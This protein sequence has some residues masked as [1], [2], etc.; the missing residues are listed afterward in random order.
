[1]SQHTA[2]NIESRG[3]NIRLLLLAFVAAGIA[4]ALVAWVL[5]TM[6]THKQEARQPFVRVVEIS[7]ISTDPEPWG[8]NWPH[9]FDGWKS[10]AGDKFYGGSSAMPESKLETQ[11]WLKR[12]YAGYAFSI[13]YR[14]ARGH[15]YMLYDQGVT[16]R[17]T[18]KPQAGA[19]LHCHASTTVLYRKVGLEAMGKEATDEAL[20]SD[21]NTEAVLRGF[22]EVSTDTYHETLANGPPRRL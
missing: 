9:Q 10:T 11:P 1:M 18:E 3:G 5:V 20:S 17:V 12:L 6:F 4:T 14:E 15:A 2:N 16:E 19:C 13:D 21:F 8:L 22:E 7:E